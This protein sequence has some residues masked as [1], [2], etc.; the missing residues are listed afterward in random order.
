ML[1]PAAMTHTCSLK[2]LRIQ[3][4]GFEADNC[5]E[6]QLLM[7]PGLCSRLYYGS[8]QVSLECRDPVSRRCTSPA[9]GD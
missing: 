6:D 7:T 3:Q 5:Q 2:G 9:V 8:E 4:L 1:D